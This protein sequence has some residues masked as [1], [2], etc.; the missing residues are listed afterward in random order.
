MTSIDTGGR[1]GCV[2]EWKNNIDAANPYETVRA[3]AVGVAASKIERMGDHFDPTAFLLTN[4]ITLLVVWLLIY[5]ICG[6][7]AA[8]VAPQGR[9]LT[10]FFI[11]LFFLGPLG[12]GFASIAPTRAPYREDAWRFRCDV[13]GALQNV[14]HNAESAECYECGESLFQSPAR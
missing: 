12:V 14:E 9:R 8:L 6:G 7:V 11:T 4:L 10:F 1:V 13:C 3:H 2:D 5:G